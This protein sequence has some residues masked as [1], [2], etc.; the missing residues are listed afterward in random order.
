MN[1]D[2]GATASMLLS[3]FAACRPLDLEYVSPAAQG[4]IRGHREPRE[5][6]GALG[7]HLVQQVQG[8]AITAACG[9]AL[10]CLLALFLGG[11]CLG[12]L[13]AQFALAAPLRNGRQAAENPMAG[14]AV[15]ARDAQ[16]TVEATR[17]QFGLVHK[18]KD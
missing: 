12:G 15:V 6:A 9:A 5:L 18:E 8:P 3:V 14:L 4:R 10:G 11:S 13:D 1:V 17:I 2:S 7:L 16:D